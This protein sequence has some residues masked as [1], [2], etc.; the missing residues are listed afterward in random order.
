MYVPDEENLDLGDEG[1]TL[2]LTRGRVEL[3]VH[4][5]AIPI[6]VTC[7]YML[8][9]LPPHIVTLHMNAISKLH[10]TLRGKF[11]GNTPNYYNLWSS[12]V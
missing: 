3:F 10:G 2:H 6:L 7:V 5:L 1:R 12:S 4:T 11:L 8:T 9:A